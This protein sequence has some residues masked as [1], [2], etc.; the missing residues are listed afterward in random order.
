M[1]KSSNEIQRIWNIE[2][3]F[4]IP[5]KWKIILFEKESYAMKFVYYI[6]KFVNERY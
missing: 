1:L 5:Y 6:S 3:S 4:K 2:F